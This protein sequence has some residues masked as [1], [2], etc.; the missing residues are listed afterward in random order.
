MHASTCKGSSNTRFRFRL[1]QH[2][3]MYDSSL[4]WSYLSYTLQTKV[5]IIADTLL[6]HNSTNK[7]RHI[8]SSY[9]ILHFAWVWQLMS[10][11]RWILPLLSVLTANPLNL[12]ARIIEDKSLR[13]SQGFVLA[14]FSRP[15]VLHGEPV[16]S[17]MAAGWFCEKSGWIGKLEDVKP[18]LSK[19]K[20]RIST[21]NHFEMEDFY[22][23]VIVK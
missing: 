2:S 14:F 12:L 10:S 18:V 13:F 22:P 19:I 8:K 3:L 1:L 6:L 15:S 23:R 20:K 7:E 9:I 5:Q 16:F 21:G 17:V 4:W 11:S